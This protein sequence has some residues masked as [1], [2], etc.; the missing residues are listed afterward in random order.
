MMILWSVERSGAGSLPTFVGRYRQFR[1]AFPADGVRVVARVTQ[2]SP[3]RP[4]PTSSSSTTAARRSPGSR[5]TN[6]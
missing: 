4:A 5:I 1:R 6:A 3:H 2:A